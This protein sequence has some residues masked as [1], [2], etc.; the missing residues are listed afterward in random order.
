MFEF[1]AF[2]ICRLDT[3]HRPPEFRKTEL[4][5]YIRSDRITGFSAERQYGGE[6]CVRLLVG[7]E[8]IFVHA[9]PDDLRRILES[10][11]EKR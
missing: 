10:S 3:D 2:F 8:K 11:K 1:I 5:L 7:Q 6:K 4:E 9:D